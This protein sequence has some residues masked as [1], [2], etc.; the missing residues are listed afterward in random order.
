MD[1]EYAPETDGGFGRGCDVTVLGNDDAYNF[2]RGDPQWPVT[3]ESDACA[4]SAGS[5]VFD[6]WEALSTS[7]KTAHPQQLADDVVHIIMTD[8]QTVAEAAD[9]RWAERARATQH[10]NG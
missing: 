7:L 1:G 5:V 10:G 2:H 6:S 9:G 8:R 3:R 4:G